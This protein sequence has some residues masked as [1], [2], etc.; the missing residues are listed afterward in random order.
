LSTNVSHLFANISRQSIEKTI[1]EK[2]NK[3]DSL[4]STTFTFHDF[5]LEDW[6]IQQ[7]KN[8]RRRTKRMS[9]SLNRAFYRSMAEEFAGNFTSD[10]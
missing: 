7:N 4:S 2:R 3:Y 10:S 9:I 8:A 1:V 5:L 6:I